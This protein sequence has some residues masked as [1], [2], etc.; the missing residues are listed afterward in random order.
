MMTRMLFPKKK[1]WPP[2]PHF[3]Q[4]GKTKRGD[5]ESGR[6]AW[7]ESYIGGGKFSP[8]H[9]IIQHSQ[10]RDTLICFLG[11]HNA[12]VIVMH[13]ENALQNLPGN[14]SSTKRSQARLERRETWGEG[15]RNWKWF[16]SCVHNNLEVNV[17]NVTVNVSKCESM[18]IIGIF[19]LFCSA[20]ARKALCNDQSKM[21]QLTRIIV[22]I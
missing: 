16:D 4:R 15:G 10:V 11:R 1:G 17:K 13:A 5:G 7:N 2:Q 6:Q 22:E 12:S 14:S 18:S 20:Y 21:L 9:L 19:L 8:L 3:V